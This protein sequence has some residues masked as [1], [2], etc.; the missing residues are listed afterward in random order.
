VRALEE[1]MRKASAQGVLFSALVARRLGINATDLECLDVILLRGRATAGELAQVT[2]LTSGAVTGIIDRLEKAG[3]ARRERDE[4]DRR[5][6]HVRALP[7]VEKKIM[8]LFVP[9]QGAMMEAIAGYGEKDLAFLLEF[10]RRSHKAAVAATEKLQAMGDGKK[11][12]ADCTEL[13][14]SLWGRVDNFGVQRRNFRGVEQGIA[15]PPSL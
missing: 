2:G 13:P 11:K 6:I 7:S 1:A 4:T 8:P 9:M 12:L 14:P 10:F 15:T 3:F 5:K